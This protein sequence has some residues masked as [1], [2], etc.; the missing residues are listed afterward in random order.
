MLSAI[1]H[2]RMAVA[3]GDLEA[4]GFSGAVGIDD[5]SPAWVHQAFGHAELPDPEPALFDICSVTKSVTAAA[6]LQL[7]SDGCLSLDQTLAQFLDLPAEMA[8]ITIR[9]V[10]AHSSGLADFLSRLGEPREYALEQ[11][12]E[13][14]SRD[15]LLRQVRRSRLLTPPGERWAYSNIGYSLLAVIVE[16]VS[17]DTFERYLQRVLFPPLGMHDT[18]YTFTIAEHPRIAAGRIGSVEWGRPTDKAGSP[19]W[20]LIGNGGLLS[21]IPDLLRWRTAFCTLPVDSSQARVAVEPRISCGYGCF[22]FETESALGNVVYHNGDNGVFSATIR[23]FPKLSR[24][25]AVVSNNSAHS[26]IV[27]ARRISD[28]WKQ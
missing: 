8:E 26:A 18:G 5:G 10:L 17:G 11:D 22:V 13:P 6:I 20:N 25:L 16:N 12:Y 21:T 23:W 4:T 19:S 27:V 14:L 3:F 15:D 2:E 24:F 28:C 1:E 7:K 9:Q